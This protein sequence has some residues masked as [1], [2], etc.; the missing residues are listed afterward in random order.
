[1]YN[2]VQ[3]KLGVLNVWSQCQIWTGAVIVNTIK[4]P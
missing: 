3:N 1:M 2:L 4:A